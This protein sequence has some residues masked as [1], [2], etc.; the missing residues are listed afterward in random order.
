LNPFR[1]LLRITE[2]LA[3][4]PLH[5]ELN[6]LQQYSAHLQKRVSLLETERDRLQQE[7]SAILAERDNLKRQVESLKVDRDKLSQYRENV[8]RQAAELKL[9]NALFGNVRKITSIREST[10]IPLGTFVLLDHSDKEGYWN[11]VEAPSDF[12][13]A[14]KGVYDPV[15]DQILFS[16]APEDAGRSSTNHLLRLD[17]ATNKWSIDKVAMPAEVGPAYDTN[18]INVSAREIYASSKLRPNALRRMSLDTGKWASMTQP[19]SIG[20]VSSEPSAEYFPERD[21][22]L[23]LQG[24]RLGAWKRSSDSWILIS[25]ILAGLGS[26]SAIAR[27][28]PVSRC[29]LIF[30]GVDTNTAPAAVSHAIY[31]YDAEGAITRLRDSPESIKIYFNRA[32]AAV[33]PLTGDLIVLQAVLGPDIVDFTGRIELWKYSVNADTW[34]KLDE[35]V[36]PATAGWW[37]EKYPS[38]LIATPISKYGV[39]MFT[40]FAGAKSSSFL[41]R[42]LTDQEPSDEPPVP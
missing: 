7:I 34:W 24:K 3:G 9:R 8:E 17:V 33:D 41:Y 29:V 20:F 19:Q 6:S 25:P 39:I 18:A 13:T 23:W 10:D 30:G 4:P 22:L 2:F 32:V 1:Y 42:H 36:V 35:S 16:S 40:S 31:K 5:A 28:I 21:E 37:A 12:G 27:Y 38:S 11:L 15:T 14:Q 26:R